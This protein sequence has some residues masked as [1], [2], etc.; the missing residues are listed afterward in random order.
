L[1]SGRDF[2]PDDRKD[3]PLV[4][5]VDDVLARRYWP[6]ES[7]VGKRVELLSAQGSPVATVVGVVGHVRNGGPREDGEPQLYLPFLQRP[8]RTLSLVLRAN[9]ARV[10]EPGA[11]VPSVR[12]RLRALDATLPLAR[13]GSME[14]VVVRAVARER[15]DLILV[16][17][18]GAAALLLA[19][20][21]L[22]GVMA[23]LVAQRTR[24]VGIRIALGGQPRDVRRLVVQQGL[25][26]A[27]IGLIGGIAAALVLARSLTSLL[28]GVRPADPATYVAIVALLLG[29]AFVASWLPARRATRIDPVAAL[30]A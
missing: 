11:L 14:D 21:G 5:I 22:Y 26:I 6:G 16:A 29:V 28:F 13:V 30:R 24:E 7:A 12:G 19:A 9:T 8:Q 20:V 10:A 23:Y 17:V 25:A 1:L 3:T 18:F 27:G 15:F 2:T 4:V